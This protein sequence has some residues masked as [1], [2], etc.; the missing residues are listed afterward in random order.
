MIK[1]FYLDMV[2]YELRMMG[3]QK[4]YDGITYNSLLYLD[5]I[6]CTPK[7]TIS[8]IAN[9]LNVAKS[10]VTLKVKELEKRGLIEKTQ[11]LRDKRIFYL[12]VKHEM[13]R[14]Y[15]EWGKSINGAVKEINENYTQEERRVFCE[16]LCIISRHY[17]N[18]GENDQPTS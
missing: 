8:Y 2:T 5:I 17:T 12:S 15:M 18:G 7:C 11:S 13:A 9:L 14:E 4:I 16:M 6:A 3:S 1:K 10:A